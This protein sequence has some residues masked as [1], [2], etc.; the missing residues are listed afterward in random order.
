MML[1]SPLAKTFV[2]LVVLALAA[3]PVLAVEGAPA[4]LLAAPPLGSPPGLLA[5]PPRNRKP[6]IE[7][8]GE[9]VVMSLTNGATVEVDGKEIGTIPLGESLVLLPGTHTLKMTRRGFT[10]YTETFEV[11]P[12]EP[13][14]IEY[15]LLPY[16]GLVKIDTAE[17]GATVKIDGKVEGVT[18]FDRD[19]P[20]GRKLITVSREGFYDEV[21]ELDI[22]AGESYQLDIQLRLMKK[23]E[24]VSGDAFYE[25][26]WFWTLVGVAGAGATAAIVAGTASGDTITPTPSFSLQVP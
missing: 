9:L 19:V 13:V 7:A 17:P 3:T 11:K 12:G 23:H 20:A 4:G 26:W 1:A 8:P 25:T 24:E 6:R 10:E 15:D 16:A 5:A 18:P 22:R 21:R 2:P 14:T